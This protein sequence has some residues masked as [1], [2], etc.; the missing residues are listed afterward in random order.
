MNKTWKEIKI[1]VGYEFKTALQL[2][3]LGIKYKL[4]IKA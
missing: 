2:N 4:P 1:Q 3:A